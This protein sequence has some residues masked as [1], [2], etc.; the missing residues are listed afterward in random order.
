MFPHAELRI[1]DRRTKRE[2]V[3]R[4]DDGGA[5]EVALHPGVYDVTVAVESWRPAKRKGLKVGPDVYCIVDFVLRPG[6]T[7]IID[8][9]HP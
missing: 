9:E 8:D 1:V 2:L 3:V 6:K 7:V 4:T 5:Y